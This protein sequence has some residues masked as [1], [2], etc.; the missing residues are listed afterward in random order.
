MPISMTGFGSAES[1][2]G[3]WFCQVEIRSVNQRFLDIRCKLPSGFQR[4]ELEITR[5]F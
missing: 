2:F 4:L 5:I 1:Q 3:A